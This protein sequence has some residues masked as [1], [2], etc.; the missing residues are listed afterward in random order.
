MIEKQ[1]FGFAWTF[2]TFLGPIHLNL[3]ISASQ[4]CQLSVT[5]KLQTVGWDCHEL[6]TITRKYGLSVFALE[7]F[8]D[9]NSNCVHSDGYHGILVDKDGQ[10]NI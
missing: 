6:A 4:L 8:G 10:L 1:N 9:D 2:E 7:K 3:S 5:C